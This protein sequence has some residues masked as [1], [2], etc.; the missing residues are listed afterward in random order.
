MYAGFWYT[1]DD[2]FW[3]KNVLEKQ[4][5]QVA[6]YIVKNK[7]K[8]NGLEIEL[9]M[10]KYLQVKFIFLT[11]QHSSPFHGDKLKENSSSHSIMSEKQQQVDV[12]QHNENVWK[13]LSEH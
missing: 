11:S 13:W 10:S 9:K 5:Q 7:S 8:G 1:I 12:E 3:R 4:F 2:V 6:T